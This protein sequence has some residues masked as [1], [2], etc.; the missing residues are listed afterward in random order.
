MTAR[1]P[2][3]RC[4][5]MANPFHLGDFRLLRPKAAYCSSG[6]REVDATAVTWQRVRARGKR[7]IELVNSAL[8]VEREQS[9][10]LDQS[11]MMCD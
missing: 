4:S 1:N 8:I 2:R 9:P 10:G 3:M 6:L 11:L 5:M 7:L